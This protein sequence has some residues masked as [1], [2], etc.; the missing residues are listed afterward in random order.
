[1]GQLFALRQERTYKAPDPNKILLG[2]IHQHKWQ[3]LRATEN[4]RIDD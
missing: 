4:G 3:S 1:M 2:T